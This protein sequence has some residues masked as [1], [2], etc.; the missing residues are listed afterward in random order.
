MYYSTVDIIRK[1]LSQTLSIV[2][3]GQCLDG[4]PT[5]SFKFQKS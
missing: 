3:L 5:W 4:G 2:V 1:L